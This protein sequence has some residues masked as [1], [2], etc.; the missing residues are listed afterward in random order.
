M[1]IF[2]NFF[3]F[4]LNRFPHTHTHSRLGFSFFSEFFPSLFSFSLTLPRIII[5]K[6]QQQEWWK[7]K[8]ISSLFLFL[9]FFWMYCCCFCSRFLLEKMR[10][11]KFRCIAFLNP[12]IDLHIST[13][14]NHHQCQIGLI[15]VPF[16]DFLTN[17]LCVCCVCVFFCFSCYYYFLNRKTRWGVPWKIETK[18]VATTEW[19]CNLPSILYYSFSILKVKSEKKSSWRV[20]SFL[21][22]RSLWI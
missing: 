2:F 13:H 22:I 20:K 21:I 15:N 19:F 8:E 16:L 3:I 17:I 4:S 10:R 9:F 12:R 1:R 5:K 14:Q 18:N 6:I 11:E 7:K